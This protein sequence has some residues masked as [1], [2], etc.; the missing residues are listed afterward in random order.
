MND[1][2]DAAQDERDRAREQEKKAKAM[3]LKLKDELDRVWDLLS[4][5]QKVL[6]L[7]AHPEHLKNYN[8]VLDEWRE[9]LASD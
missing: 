7:K 1:E 2:R 8:H 3:A 6:Y 4:S 5:D 9:E